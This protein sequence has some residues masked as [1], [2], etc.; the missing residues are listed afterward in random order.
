MEQ[1]LINNNPKVLS[2]KQILKK[3]ASAI[4]LTL[5]VYFFIQQLTAIF[6]EFSAICMT[7]I[8]VRYFADIVKPIIAFLSSNAGNWFL[9][10]IVGATAGLT[11]IFFLSKILNFRLKPLYQPPYKGASYSIK[12]TVLFLDANLISS[13]IVTIFLA[14]FTSIFGVTPSSPDFSV[15]YHQPSAVIFFFL[16]AAI[17]APIVEETLFRGIILRSLQNFGNIFAI[18]ASSFLFGLW[19][20]NFEQAIPILCSSVLFG[21]IAIRSNSIVPSIIAHSLNNIII[22]VFTFADTSL[23]ASLAEVINV[24]VFFVL[25]L[26]GTLILAFSL[27]SLKVSD[28]NRSSLSYKQRFASVCST[29]AIIALIFVFVLQFGMT[30]MPQ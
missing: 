30:L 25:M 27:S 28:L 23:S 14:I 22:A 17:V 3:I 7:T 11:S 19:H 6:F 18:V 24:G 5:I 10:L 15:S 8:G 26:A 13:A 2:D 16:Y 1:T 21:I 12:G 4:G 9:N 29:P 20:G